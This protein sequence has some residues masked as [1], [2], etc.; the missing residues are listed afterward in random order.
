MDVVRESIDGAAGM[1]PSAL[2][3][4]PEGDEAWWSAYVGRLR[5]VA[6]ESA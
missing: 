3:L 4:P 2:N 6:E 1:L 5:Q